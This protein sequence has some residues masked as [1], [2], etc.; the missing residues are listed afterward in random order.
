MFKCSVVIVEGDPHPVATS[1]RM[2]FLSFNPSID[3]SVKGSIIFNYSY[4]FLLAISHQ[5]FVSVETQ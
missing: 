1:G 4:N 2:S 3:V 5:K